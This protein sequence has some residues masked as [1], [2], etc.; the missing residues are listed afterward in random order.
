Q[1]HS[2]YILQ[3][4]ELPGF[5]K[6]QQRLLA[7]LVRY[8]INLFKLSELSKFAR[9]DEQDV[10]ALVRLLRLAIILNKSRQA[11]E[12]TEQI[13][14]TFNRALTHWTLKFAQGYLTHTPLIC[15]ELKAEKRV[16]NE[17]GLDITF[18]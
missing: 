13:T 11:T 5:D 18:N 16:L 9:Y 10:L 8:Q 12:K 17:M 2:A 4:I 1:K 6:E 15:N 3:N 14:L 7:T